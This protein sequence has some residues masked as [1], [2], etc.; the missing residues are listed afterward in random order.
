MGASIKNMRLYLSH[1]P[2]K[3]KNFAFTLFDI[4]NVFLEPN[5]V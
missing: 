5:I 2:F 3:D 1:C 4:L